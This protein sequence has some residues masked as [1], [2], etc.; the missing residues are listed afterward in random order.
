MRPAL[1]LSAALVALAPTTTMA[2]GTE[3]RAGAG[4]E[5]I[6]E[7][8]VTGSRTGARVREVATSISVLPEQAL[9][10]QLAVS[11]NI[12]AVLD[13]TVPGLNVS[14][15]GRGGCL[16]KIRGRTVNFQINGVPAN[17]ELRPS[18]CNS[19]FQVNPFALEQV[20][21]VRG[22]TALYGA[23]APGGIVNLITR[24]ARGEGLEVDAVVQTSFNTGEPAGTWRHDLYAGVGQLLGAADYYVGVGYQD[25]GAARGPDGTWSVGTEYTS[26]SLNGSFGLDLGAAGRLRLTGTWYHEEPG[27]EYGADGAEIAAG[28]ARPRVIAVEG[29][30]FLDDSH[31][32]LYTLALSYEVDEVLGHRLFL[33]AFLQEQEY[34]Q[35][36]NFQ[37]YNGG[38]NDF[39]ADD[40]ENGGY[41][42]RSTLARSVDLG[43]PVLEFQY[44][45]D[46]QRSR[47]L[48][49]LL[50]PEDP[51]RITGYIAP[52]VILNTYGL[53]AQGELALGDLRLTGGA[54][55]EL[56][57][58]EVGDEAYDPTL[59]R[60]ATP[61][62]LGESEL[63]LFNVGAIYDLT[64]GLQL[65]G[66]FSQGAELSQLGRAARG[67]SDPGT[68]TPEP[69]TSDQYE[70]GLRGSLGPLALSVAA[71]YS[72]S[73]KA[74]LLQGDPS[75]AGQAFCPLIPLRV[76]QRFHGVEG[77]V[78]WT[79]RDGLAVGALLTWQK[80]KVYNEDLGRYIDYSTDQVSP[81]RVTGHVAVEPVA[82]LNARLQ[83]TYIGAADYFSP[84]EQA[85]GYINTDAVFLMDLSASY[86][87]GPGEV[88]A[89]IANLLDRRYVNVALQGGGFAET[90]AE[91][92]RLTLGYRARF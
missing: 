16:T 70:L 20:E 83:A 31:D 23:G 4:Q 11:Q 64:D 60:P 29:N 32:R 72:E 79:V 75:C 21:V 17:Q 3:S 87:V 10:D 89:S 59:P 9:A 1:L 61:G 8:T 58:G 53:F 6:E 73:D 35:R 54:R 68:I 13:V 39:F 37:E 85:L 47:V 77:T 66:G 28:V 45:A 27:Q 55:H 78:D 26:W 71:F 24:R 36:A 38:E 63:S 41:G 56:Y 92:R 15:G 65:Y 74:S 33:S 88:V 62:D 49:L 42:L 34:L 5:E 90:L 50:D 12:L 67:I 80:G 82:G 14:T 19:V 76:P 44:G 91:G 48:R 18:T 51:G 86:A 52:E 81:F 43:G 2:Q 25:A 84:G 69:A 57:R 30:P 22:A 7:I 46:F 40:R